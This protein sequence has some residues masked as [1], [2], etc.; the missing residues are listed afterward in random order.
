MTLSEAPKPFLAERYDLAGGLSLSL[1]TPD[2]AETAG[3]ICA[4]MDPWLSYP[5]SAAELA[6]FFARTEPDAPR[7]TLGT[8]GDFAGALTVRR[9]WLRG[10]YVHMLMI[11]PRYQGRG[12]GTALLGWVEAQARLGG[13]RNLW[14]AVTSTNSSGRKLYERF[15][16]TVTAELDGLVRDGKTELLMRKRLA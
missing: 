4:G 6:A 7:F 8:T 2:E 16:F 3:A 13:D 12:L 14:I 10:P 11:A 5:F 9:N 15:G 1:M